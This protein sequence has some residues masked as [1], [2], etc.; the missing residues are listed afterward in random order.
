[1]TYVSDPFG[2]PFARGASDR[3]GSLLLC[4]LFLT[5]SGLLLAGLA[6]DIMAFESALTSG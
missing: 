5:V 1:M 2:D 4:L 6:L 3:V